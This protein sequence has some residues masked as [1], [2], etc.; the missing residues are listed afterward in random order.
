MVTDK[1]TVGEISAAFIRLNVG[2]VAL[3]NY[4]GYAMPE[5]TEQMIEGCVKDGRPLLMHVAGQLRLLKSCIVHGQ[6]L[7]EPYKSIISELGIAD[8][9][10]DDIAEFKANPEEVYSNLYKGFAILMWFDPEGARKIATA[11]E[12]GNYETLT[13]DP[14]EEDE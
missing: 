7:F 11:I 4:L 13:Q 14:D 6:D 8:V 9:T 5:I 1:L 3:S 2:V 12:T 10:P